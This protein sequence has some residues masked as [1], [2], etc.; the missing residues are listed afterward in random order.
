[1]MVLLLL[2]LLMLELVLLELILLLFPLL[3]LL[4]SVAEVE[5]AFVDGRVRPREM[6]GVLDLAEDH[7]SVNVRGGLERLLL[8]DEGLGGG[9]SLSSISME[10]TGGGGAGRCGEAEISSA[11]RVVEESGDGELVEGDIAGEA[12]KAEEEDYGDDEVQVE[13]SVEVRGGRKV[14]LG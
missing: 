10:S 8:D 5:L 2:L 11:L 1:M 12:A 3:L 14:D 9:G 13:M 4:T 7:R 6:R